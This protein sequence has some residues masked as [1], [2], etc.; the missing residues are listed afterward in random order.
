MTVQTLPHTKQRTQYRDIHQQVTDTIIAQLEK[1]TIPWHQPWKGQ[2]SKG[3]FELPYNTVS[4]NYYQGVNIVLLWGSA[5]EKQFDTGEWATF[6]QWSEKKETIRKG[7]K[8]T[9]IVYYDVIEKEEDG[10]TKRIP[11]LKSYH[12]F[13]RCQLN[14]YEPKEDISYAETRALVE[15]I[16]TVDRFVANTKAIIEHGAEGA[17]Y[18]PSE[19]KIYM[20]SLEA[21]HD[22]TSC[23]ATEGYYS[24]LLH[25]L[26]HWSGASTRLDRTKGK[27]FGDNQYAVEELV[28]E[29]GSAFLCA[30]HQITT[31]EKGDHASYIAHWL[32]VLKDNKYCLV[33]AASE[34]SKAVKYMKS[35]TP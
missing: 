22:T 34:A 30:E 3:Y 10:E 8:G 1:G 13:N 17:F 6:K 31:A 29:L 16:E 18:R 14:G 7:E 26:V 5:I 23:T 15:R 11:Y 35:L 4:T 9:M 32:K 33:T 28:A 20:P 24:T 21:F 25:E 2:S 19:D 27:R 12:V